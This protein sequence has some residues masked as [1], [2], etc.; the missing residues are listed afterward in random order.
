MR[1]QPLLC[2]EAMPIVKTCKLVN[3]A[4]KAGSHVVTRDQT[5]DQSGRPERSPRDPQLLPKISS[6]KISHQ[7]LE[8]SHCLA[9]FPKCIETPPILGFFPNALEIF[10]L[11]FLRCINQRRGRNVCESPHKMAAEAIIQRTTSI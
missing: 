11:F 4:R 10:H 5:A 1:R 2:R 3:Q 6:T 9:L 8:V 7:N